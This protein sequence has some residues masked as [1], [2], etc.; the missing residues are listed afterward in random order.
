[1]LGNKKRYVSD[2]YKEDRPNVWIKFSEAIQG[3]E[4]MVDLGMGF[5]SF[6]TPSIL[7]EELANIA[8]DPSYHQPPPPRGIP[9][10]LDAIS[11]TY[12]PLMD[13]RIT[14]DQVITWLGA[15]GVLYLAIRALVGTGDEVILL[16][17]AFEC[18]ETRSR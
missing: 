14:P 12:S 17:P 4:D 7:L 1:M 9:P 15:Q 8:R 6:P 2:H 16:E 3:R 11:D 18:Y 13:R 5:P 10:L